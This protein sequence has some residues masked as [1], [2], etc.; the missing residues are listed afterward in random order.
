VGVAA[1][2][3]VVGDKDANGVPT[4]PTEGR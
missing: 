2:V 3:R 4:V 1:G